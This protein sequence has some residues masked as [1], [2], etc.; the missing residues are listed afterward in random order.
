MNLQSSIDLFLKYCKV[1]KNLSKNT[2]RMYKIDLEN[3]KLF[4]R[5]DIDIDNIDKNIIKDYLE[6]LNQKYTKI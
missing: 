1:Q 5:N 4:V 6:H 3:F 2:L